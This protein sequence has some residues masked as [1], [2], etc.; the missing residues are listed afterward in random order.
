MPPLV[1]LGLSAAVLAATWLFQRQDAHA[2]RA[3]ADLVATQGAARLSNSLDDQLHV[4]SLMAESTDPRD[5]GSGEA[6]DCYA[7]NVLYTFYGLRSIG[8]SRADGV[9]AWVYPKLD[10]EHV[11]GTHLFKTVDPPDTFAVSM[12][13]LAVKLAPPVREPDG[14]LLAT[15]YYPILFDV[16]DRPADGREIAGYVSGVFELDRILCTL[17]VHESLSDYEVWIDTGDERLASSSIG[18]E[19]APE[20]AYQAT[21]SVDALN[22]TW[23]LGAAHVGPRSPFGGPALRYGF[24]ALGLLVAAAVSLALL[25]WNQRQVNQLRI[26]EE[27]AELESRLMQSQKIEAVGRLAGGVA[28]DF[29]NL[30]TAIIG[31]A[32]LLE[33]FSELDENARSA[34]DQIRVAGERATHLTSQLLTISRK[35]VVQP[36]AIDL[37]GELR[38]LDG[39]LKRLLRANVEFFEDFTSD[40][41]IVELDPGQLSQIAINLFVN[42]VDAMPNGGTITMRTTCQRTSLDGEIRDWVVLS[43]E[44]TGTGMDESARLRA[45]EPFFTTKET[46]KGTGLGLATVDGITTRAG[47]RVKIESNQPRGTKVSIW[48]P[49]SSQRPAAPTP[50]SGTHLEGGTAL[51]V[52]DEPSVLRI[53]S[54]ILSEAGYKIIEAKDG[55]DALRRVEQGRKFDLLVTDA[56]MPRLGG[57]EMLE[58]LRELLDLKRL[59]ASFLPKPF[60]EQ[61]LR[62]SVQEAGELKSRSTERV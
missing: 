12:D 47:G 58:R 37:N 10:N 52:E 18:G 21:A 25:F 45:L 59:Q 62:E 56:V 26:I 49:A 2:E 55:L 8:W 53:A 42:G 46:G 13:D 30:L 61:S 11:L 27:R 6:L 15:A 31:N 24:L 3:Q 16:E 50:P 33:S 57:R 36:R 41:C 22:L 38:T 54:R 28:H 23:S 7:Q 44:D 60:T 1:F 43:V 17:L 40:S 20:G 34:L 5:L 48:L 32:D 39:V 51:V 9:I 19:P 29:N 4:I 35:Q 14:N